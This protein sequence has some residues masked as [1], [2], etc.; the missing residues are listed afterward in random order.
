[1]KVNKVIESHKEEF[2]FEI[3]AKAFE[4]KTRQEGRTKLRKKIAYTKQERIKSA[5]ERKE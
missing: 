1:M 4:E 5:I 3:E 2:K